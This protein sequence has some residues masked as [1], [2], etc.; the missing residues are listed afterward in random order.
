MNIQLPYQKVSK[1]PWGEPK[2]KKAPRKGKCAYLQKGVKRLGSKSFEEE[3]TEAKRGGQPRGWV[4]S[5]QRSAGGE[6][7]GTEILGVNRKS[8]RW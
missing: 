7:G 8:G 2:G 1:P 4:Y 5:K 3:S 6:S